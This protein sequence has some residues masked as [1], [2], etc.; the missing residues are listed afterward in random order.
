M[1]SGRSTCAGGAAMLLLA[2]QAVANE[3]AIAPEVRQR[4]DAVAADP[5]VKQALDVVKADEARTLAEQKAIVVI[6][7]AP[8]KEA[9]RAEDFRNRLA[10]LGLRN[11]QIDR[12][13]NVIAVR[14]GRGGGPKLVVS[15][16]LD[17]VF[18][19][20]TDLTVSEKN[21]RI[22]APGIADDA[23]GLVE[24][25]SLV[26]ALDAAKIRTVGDLRFVGT[27]GEEGLGDLRGVRAL[28]TQN[29]DIDGFI[30]ID[31]ATPER[32]TFVAVGSK[33]YRATFSGPGGHSLNDFGRPS[34][35]HAMGRAIARIADLRTPALPK[36]TFTVGT[37]TGGTSVN[38]IAGDAA[39]ELDMRSIGAAEL[40]AL[41]DQAL[42]AIDAAVDEENARWNH[43]R[44]VSV[45]LEQVGA[46]PGGSQPAD[47]PIIQACVLANQSVGL[48]PMLEAPASTD[49]NLPISLGIPAMTVG[50]GGATGD[51]HAVTEWFD[52][53]DAYLGVQKNLLT[54]LSLVGVDGVS[55]PI[56]ARRPERR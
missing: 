48:K 31:G 23:R 6:P 9:K 50:R 28:F 43:E 38:A 16:H 40:L 27:V 32:I 46:R 33:R 15:A 44:K 24:I 26:R 54:V 25:L 37:V 47:A 39:F 19:E 2:S 10:A 30:S 34:A 4:F 21:G 29:N 8:F 7:A 55:E 35:I 56:L 18:P 45:K 14:P 36:T 22:Y 17:T 1:G 11:A 53:K 42:K 49:A 3:P 41:E 5:A 51:N 13:G 52:P 12:E 20:K